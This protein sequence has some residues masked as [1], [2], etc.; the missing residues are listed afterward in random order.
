MRVL[1]IDDHA[2]FGELLRTV[3]EALDCIVDVAL[4]PF[5]GVTLSDHAFYDLVLLDQRMP[6]RTGME[7]LPLL[8]R[9]GHRCILIVT[10]NL[11]EVT[12]EAARAAG[13]QGVLPKPLEL[14]RLFRIVRFIRDQDSPEVV[15]LPERLLRQLQPDWF[16]PA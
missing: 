8:A 7:I 13:A 1:V 9:R 5:A 16:A 4:T 10:G 2:A 14:D 15:Q 12:P 11:E 3:L 6:Q